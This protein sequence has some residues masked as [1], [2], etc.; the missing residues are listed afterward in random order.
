MQWTQSRSTNPNPFCTASLQVCENWQLI[1]VKK[2]NWWVSCYNVIMT[3]ENCY[4]NV[5]LLTVSVLLNISKGKTISGT[6]TR[7]NSLG[8]ESISDRKNISSTPEGKPEFYDWTNAG[9]EGR[10]KS[11][12][13]GAVQDTVFCPQSLKVLC[14]F[15]YESAL[16]FYLSANQQAFENTASENMRLQ[17]Q[18][19]L[20]PVRQSDSLVSKGPLNALLEVIL[21]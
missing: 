7:L 3:I 5:V 20:L 17:L 15:F 11:S 18:S 12:Q 21:T 16:E 13:F 9:A 4:A 2:W 8:L 19:R 14:L 10:N 1:M 6:M